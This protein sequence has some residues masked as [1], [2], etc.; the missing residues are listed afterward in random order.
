MS[1]CWLAS[2]PGAGPC[3]GR[4]VRVHLIPQQ[5]LRREGHAKACRDP[6]SWVLACGGVMGNAGHHGQL[7][8]ARTLRIP[9]SRLP[10]GVE[11]LA[12]ELGLDWWLDR[13]YPPGT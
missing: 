10:V 7:D 13:T 8:Y 11:D 4:L 3:D 6:R 2:L 5:L 1:R 9:R 12:A